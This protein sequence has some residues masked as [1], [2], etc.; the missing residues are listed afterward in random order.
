M[1]SLQN[2]E[3]GG[4]QLKDAHVCIPCVLV[5]PNRGVSEF[6]EADALKMH[7]TP[8]SEIGLVIVVQVF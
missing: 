8:T 3:K 4:Q 1:A 2:S 7:V 5:V 6:D